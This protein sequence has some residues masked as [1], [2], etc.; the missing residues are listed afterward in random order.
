MTVSTAISNILSLAVPKDGSGWASKSETPTQ[1]QSQPITQTQQV[2]PQRQTSATYAQ[3]SA[4]SSSFY[5]IK[6]FN[7]SLFDYKSEKIVG[8]KLYCYSRPRLM[9]SF[10]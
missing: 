3:P 10:S 4:V 5:E 2:L 9:R 8:W 6:N 1:Q 7:L